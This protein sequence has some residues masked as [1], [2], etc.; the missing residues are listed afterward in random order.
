[1]QGACM[2]AC[3]VGEGSD[4]SLDAWWVIEGMIKVVRRTGHCEFYMRRLESLGTVADES[5][6]TASFYIEKGSNAVSVPWDR[7]LRL[8]G[9]D[10]EDFIACTA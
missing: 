7:N 4:V 3:A 2:F 10:L 6:C 5:T 8:T 9:V 1:M